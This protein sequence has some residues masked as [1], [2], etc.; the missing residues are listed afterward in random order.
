MRNQVFTVTVREVLE[1]LGVMAGAFER[2]SAGLQPTGTYILPLDAT[3]AA[4]AIKA[5]RQ[6]VLQLPAWIPVDER[7]PPDNVAVLVNHDSGGVEMA[8]RE[9]GRWYISHAGVSVPDCSYTHWMPLPPPPG[10]EV[11]G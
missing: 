10:G 6:L 2:L 9:G 7:L 5:A 11:E 4:A 3:S 8:F 1:R